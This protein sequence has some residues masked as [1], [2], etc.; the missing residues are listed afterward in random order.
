MQEV[1]G[2]L[3]LRHTVQVARI[4]R[5]GRRD[6]NPQSQSIGFTLSRSP[7][8]CICIIHYSYLYLTLVSQAEDI[9]LAALEHGLEAYYDKIPIHTGGCSGKLKSRTK[10]GQ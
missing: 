5:I 9:I 8:L 10:T 7:S 6:R 1:A 2:E 4:T 3:I